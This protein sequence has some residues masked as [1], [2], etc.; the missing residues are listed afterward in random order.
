MDFKL[1]DEQQM[2]KDMCRSFAENELKPKAEHYDRTHEFPWE[3]VKK[4]GEMGLM[5]IVYPEKYNGAGMDYLSYAI[6]IE[7]L[8]RGCASTGVICSAHNSLCLSPIYYFGTEEQKMKYLPKL[9]TGEWIGCFGITEPEAGSDAAGTKTTAEFKNGKW[10][11]NGTKNFI[12]NGGVADVAVITAVTEKGLG[13]KGLSFFIVEKGTPGFSV[14][15]TENKLG[16]CASSTTEL[17]FDNCEIP[18][19]NLLGKKGEGFKIAM[20][21]LDGGRVGIAAQAVGI[22]QAAFEA[23]KQYAM[24]RKQFGKSISSFQAIQWMIADMATEIEAA[25]LLVY[26]AAT[27]LNTGER[28][29]YSKYSAMAKLFASETSHRVTHKALQIF[30]GYGYIKDYPVERYYRD[31]RITE[32]YEGTSEIQRLVIANNELKG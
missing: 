18:E 22:A 19:E 8:S 27:F 26:Q 17:V 28:Q 21:T 10:I 29:R 5:G 9:C 3:H 31:A 7:E 20:H 30:G 32:I 12:T 14:G 24:E 13:H 23:A 25:R 15:K 16:I 2:L 1:T 11:L 6:A 4:M